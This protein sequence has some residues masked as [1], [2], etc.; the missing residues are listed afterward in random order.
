MEPISAALGVAGALLGIL[1]W[2]IKRK[3]AKNDD[4]KEQLKEAY[5]EIDK[6]I[7]KGGGGVVDI[8]RMVADFERM[9][10]ALGGDTGE[11]GNTVRRNELHSS[12]CCN[13]NPPPQPIPGFDSW[14]KE[15]LTNEQNTK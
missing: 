3:A 8:N 12:A 14:T 4:P 6:A 13:A 9:Q 15:R 2:W 7:S 5:N 11:Q 10:D 1:F